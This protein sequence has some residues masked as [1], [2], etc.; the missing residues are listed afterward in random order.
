M[1]TDIS[2][3]HAS[4]KRSN[5]KLGKLRE[6]RLDAV[7]QFVGAHYS[8]NGADKV[9]PTNMIELAT[10]VYLRLLAARAPRCVVSTDI[11]AL[12]PFAADMEIVLNQIPGE[13]GLSDTLRR[14]VMEAMFS[15]GIVKVGIGAQNSTS[16]L[17]DEP[18][19]CNVQL[20][21]YFVD[22]SARSWNE[23]Q[24]EGDDY[25]IDLEQAKSLYGEELFAD[26]YD[27]T[28]DDGQTQAN[29]IGNGESG[30]EF[31]DRILL[32]DVYLVRENKLV[33]YAVKTMKVLREVD[34]DGPEGTPYLKLFFSDVPGNLMPLAPVA[35]WRDLHNLG[36]VLFRKLGKQA[37]SRK[38][39]LAFQGGSDEQIQRFKNAKD[40]DGIRYDGS[41]PESIVA[42][43]IDQPTLAFYLSAWDRF[44]VIC[45][46]LDSLGGL[47]A[48]ADTASQ[49]K[50][51]GDASSARI[52]AMGDSVTEFAR[53][54]FKRLAWY[55]WTDPV[56]ERHYHKMM[57]KEY[58]IGVSKK[59]TPE[60]RDGDF[61]DYNFDID[62]FS[63]QDDSPSTR[64]QKL[65]TVFERFILPLQD[66]LA[67]QGAYIDM[68]SLA[69]YISKN[70]NL[71][72]LMEMVKFQDA[73]SQTD[74]EPY[75]SP[76]PTTEAPRK[77]PFSRREYVRVNRP[78]ATRHGR[79]AALMQT[80]L[81]GH[82][83]DSE[84]AGLAAGRSL[85]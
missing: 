85:T 64:L 81:G 63:M 35:V 74:R 34:W 54:I 10:T 20:D 25:W 27:G 13:I 36:N 44:N 33:T 59:W 43:G 71:P 41:K 65:M 70:S 47:S 60:T 68:R 53:Q 56:A 82:V 30:F 14:A 75:G 79:D 83:Q 51:I 11:R 57:S 48:Q 22:M 77:S 50:L 67:Q 39:V 69:D 52:K 24:Y 62:V 16:K 61:L 17:G 40:G 28:S 18:F 46:N 84:A 58:G 8:E 32:R 73:Q 31:C 80:L 4:I 2:R 37:Q 49:E 76:E 66:Q 15:I 12:R 1:R 9:V 29:S 38:A 5:E 42:G 6:E 26:S 78:G 7:K 3:L 55:L 72:E 19:V 23:I 45:G 21:D